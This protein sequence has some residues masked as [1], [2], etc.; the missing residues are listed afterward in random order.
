MKRKLDFK[1]LLLILFFSINLLANESGS[2]LQNLNNTAFGYHAINTSSCE[3]FKFKLGTPSTVTVIGTIKPNFFSVGDW[4]NPTGVWNFY[5]AETNGTNAVFQVDTTTGAVTNL[6]N[7]TG[8]LPGH[9]I[10]LMEWDHTTN[11]FFIVSATSS[12]SSSQLYSLNWTTKAL[13]TIGASNTTCPGITVGGFN[14]TGIL[15]VIDHISGNIYRI[16]KTNGMST[17]VGH[18]GFTTSI[19]DEGAFDRSDWKF[20]CATSS[21][22]RQLDS[23]FNGATQIGSFP[24]TNSVVSVMCVVSFPFTSINQTSSE[25]LNSYS[26]F[27]NYP[28]PFNPSTIIRFKIKDSGFTSLKIYD[29]LGKEVATLVNEKL[30]PGEYE[31][32][33]DGS[34]YSSGVYFYKF[35]AGDF[36]ETKK[37]ILIK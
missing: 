16:N 10:T 37:M 28:N 4:A 8:I 36:S 25:I 21:I 14:R 27:Q 35:E 32:E 23:N 26:L 33:F 1:I 15:F 5:V 29:I 31:I 13:T 18:S 6:G 9:S 12:F 34:D 11:K 22:L 17:F 30:Q 3:L 20:Y 2:G 7:I 19:T 24:F